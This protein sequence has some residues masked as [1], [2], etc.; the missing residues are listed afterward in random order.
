MKA[1]ILSVFAMLFIA[2]AG[3]LA[4]DGEPVVQIDHIIWAVPDLD[5]G[6]QHLAELSGVEPITGGIHPGR[7]TRNKLIGAGDN[8]YLEVIAPDP[9]QMP[10][11]PDA[12]PVQA[13]ADRISKMDGPEVDM[14]AYAS[15]DLEY[16]AEAGR[17]LGLQV[18]GPTPGQRRTP[19]GE[20]IRWSHVDFVGHG[21]G[22]F[23]PFAINWLDS[24]H[25]STTSPGGA[26]I[27]GITVQHPR[28][29]ELRRIYEGLRIPAKVIQGDE[30]VIIVHMRSDKGAFELR[31][32]NSLFDYYAARSGDNI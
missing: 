26:V 23:I 24:P 5:A 31:S 9:A 13:F 3:A 20:L 16:M 1:H 4:A 2:G 27:E 10:L 21:F 28:A 19:G 7:G 17:K 15:S 18:V 22:Q 11:D 14:Y 30:P 25:P 32:G 12:N 8:M 29:D 6:A